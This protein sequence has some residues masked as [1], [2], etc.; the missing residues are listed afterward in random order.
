M[1]TEWFLGLCQQ[2]ADWFLS[3]F[4]EWDVPGDIVGFDNTLNGFVGS[5][6]G[7]GVWVPWTL[8]FVC[9]G[10]SIAAYLIGLSV[11]AGRWVLGLVPTMGGGT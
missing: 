7:L 6:D 3:L 9:V 2:I 10:I 8:L 1:I 4:P 11:R 5:F